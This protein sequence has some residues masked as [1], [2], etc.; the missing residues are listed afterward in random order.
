MK[1]Q[2]VISRLF[3]GMLFAYTNFASATDQ[4]CEYTYQDCC[5]GCWG[6][7]VQAGVYPTLWRNRGDLLL[8]ACDCGTGTLVPIDLG[9][10]PKFSRLFSTPWIVGGQ[11]T[12]DWS[13]HITLYGEL[14]YIQASRKKSGFVTDVNEAVNLRLGHY[15]A[16]SGYFGIRYYTCP[17][18][19]DTTEFFIGGKVGFLARANI[20]AHNLVTTE[21][22]TDVCA[23]D[24]SF[25]RDFYRHRT[26]VSGGLNFGA[27]IGFCSCWSFVIT[28]E[29]VATR[30]PRGGRCL[31]LTEPEI[32]ALQGGSFIASPRIKT[33]LS[34]PVTFGLKYHF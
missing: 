7:Q 18:F 6:L 9:K 29:V 21:A 31:A 23:C 12:Y 25:K 22:V 15:R 16:V 2:L 17:M 34:F 30:G 14:N 32:F 4:C 5:G 28:G 13:Q 33:E 10:F 8:N 3:I 11:V 20:H 27:D 26:D 19:C 24:F 1:K